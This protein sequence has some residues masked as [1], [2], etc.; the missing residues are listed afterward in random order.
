MWITSRS[1]SSATRRASAQVLL[2]DRLAR[3]DGRRRSTAARPRAGRRRSS[4]PRRPRC[5][6]RRGR[7]G[8]RRRGCGPTAASSAPA[9][10]VR[11]HDQVAAGVRSAG[12]RAPARATTVAGARG[13]AVPPRPRRPGGRAGALGGRAWRA[14]GAEHGEPGGHG[15]LVPRRRCRSGCRPASAA[16]GADARPA[17]RDRAAG[18][19]T[20]APTSSTSGALRKKSGECAILSTSSGMKSGS[21]G[22]SRRKRQHRLQRAA[23]LERCLAGLDRTLSLRRLSP[24]DHSH[25]R[26]PR[27]TPARARSW[28]LGTT[29]RC[30]GSGQAGPVV[31]G[32]RRTTS[33]FRAQGKRGSSRRA[34]LIPRRLAPRARG[35]PCAGLRSLLGVPSGGGGNRPKLTFIGWKVSAM[36]PPVMWASSAPCAVSGGGGARRL[37]QRLGGGEPAGQQADGG[38]LDIAL[39]A[40]DLA[41]EADMRR[42]LQAQGRVEQARAVDEGVAV[43]PAQPRELAPAPARGSVRNTRTC[44]ACFSLV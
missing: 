36:A 25:P 18:R 32:S 40:G 16:A 4:R 42:R 39:A 33:N 7:A 14:A 13:A 1:C 43:Q 2:V 26:A 20:S 41:G 21:S 37:A 12:R 9:L 29:T 8:C 6:R 17:A 23:H 3:P 10:T 27:L 19:P 30:C 35:G 34:A 38:A 24:P 44:S 11:H 5:R 15:G 31:C 28:D 22:A